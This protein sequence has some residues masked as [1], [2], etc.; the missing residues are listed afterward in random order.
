MP[1]RYTS[2]LGLS[3]SRLRVDPDTAPYLLAGA[4]C[5]VLGLVLWTTARPSS[6]P[7]TPTSTTAGGKP[8]LRRKNTTAAS[9]D[10]GTDKN[11]A[12]GTETLV[13][14]F[15]DE[16]GDGDDNNVV[17]RMVKHLLTLNAK[18]APKIS[19]TSISATA[20]HLSPEDARRAVVSRTTGQHLELPPFAAQ[21][22]YL[23]AKVRAAM[24]PAK[25]L[26]VEGAPGI[27][28]A[29]ALVALAEYEGAIRP[30]AIYLR[31]SDALGKRHGGSAFEDDGEEDERD[32]VTISSNDE[33]DWQRGLARA[34][35]YKRN[36][37]T[38]DADDGQDM[39]HVLAS[40]SEA[41]RLVASASTSTAPSP[42]LI[43]DDIQLVFHS[44]RLLVERY[45]GLEETFDWFL[46]CTNEGLLDVVLCSSEK[47]A[48][49][50]IRRLRGYDWKLS[51][52]CLESVDD[53]DVV[54]YLLTSVNPQL[55][56]HQKLSEADA[57]EFV[58]NFGGN[59][60]ELGRYVNQ[61]RPLKDFIEQRETDHIEYLSKH[62]PDGGDETVLR[63]FILS[64]IFR[65]GVMPVQQLE[66]SQLKLVENLLEEGNFLRWRDGRARR[67][68]SMGRNSIA[69]LK[70]LSSSSSSPSTSKRISRSQSL[71]WDAAAAAVGG[72]PLH[73]RSTSAAYFDEDNNND[74]DDDD[75]EEEEREAQRAQDEEAENDPFALFGRMG[76]E[77][78]WYNAHVQRVCERWFNESC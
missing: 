40:I 27:G 38:S 3:P 74:D 29:T 16:D 47:S 8:L 26:L 69:S 22:N 54:E 49:A 44:H 23:V 48:L 62:L 32:D 20:A 67:R 36:A 75:E 60:T 50:G 30:A 41:L 31:L 42:L 9:G 52:R 78:V 28:K 43:V 25:V 65:N 10:H 63:D 6:S 56:E 5:I 21:T 35:G 51:Y 77:L 73:E 24:Q 15:D 72:T 45:A 76:A 18:A 59:M 64:M 19:A 33:N 68:E 34:F 4:A 17:K 39:L 12:D 57:Y 55:M 37:D 46:Q 53:A 7:P 11:T 66:R 58:A 1:V 61:D 71:A 70:S 13:F 14:E 2:A